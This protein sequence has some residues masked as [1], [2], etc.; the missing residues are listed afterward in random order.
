MATETTPLVAEPDIVKTAGWPRH[1]GGDLSKH[2]S[3]PSTATSTAPEESSVALSAF[4]H[5]FVLIGTLLIGWSYGLDGLLRSTYQSYA[6]SE[7]GKHSLLATINVLRNVIAAA[8]YPPAAKLADVVGRL[9]LTV[10]SVVVYVAGTAIQAT[11]TSVTWFIVGAVLYQIGYTAIILLV[12]VV[13]ADITS[14]RSRLF[15][16]YVPAVPFMVNA[17]VSGDIASIVMRN[18]TWRWGIGMWC[19]IYTASAV[20]MLIS[21]YQAGLYGSIDRQHH[22]KMGVVPLHQRLV[23]AFHRLDVVGIGLAVTALALILTPLATAGGHLSRWHDPA[24]IASLTLGCLCTVGF[25]Y[26]ESRCAKIPLMPRY[27]LVD[28]GVIA[29]L[30]IRCLLNLAWA[31]QANYLYTVLIVAFD[32]SVALATQVTAFFTFFGVLSGLVVGAIVYQTRR[33]KPFILLGI[34]LLAAS[35]SILIWFHSGTSTAARN[36]MLAAQAL[37]GVAAGFC[38]YPTQAL[39]QSASKREHVS[40]MTGIY[41]AIFNIG[42]ALGTCIAGVIWSEVLPSTLED[43]LSFQQNS[44]LARSIYQSPFDVVPHY[45][46]GTPIRSAVITSY[47]KVQVLL[48]A[49]ALGLCI[50]MVAIGPWLSNPKLSETQTGYGDDREEENDDEN[51]DD[52]H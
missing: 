24:A 51:D 21:L 26:W 3:T 27:L 17:W 29:A 47:G 20:P 39:V 6:A 35:F 37:L 28:R 13:I 38:A 5:A 46:V 30:A 34:I 40:A 2:T 42:S 50:P 23:H 11:S 7:F 49:T 12:E 31:V 22:H 44:T 9:E 1:N 10:V 8:A 33:L 19:V 41:L 52:T 48:A 4:S 15:L 36:G 45:P 16:S 18:T 14:M 32:F 43:N 25:V